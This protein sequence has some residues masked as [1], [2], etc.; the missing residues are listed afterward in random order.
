MVAVGTTMKL[1]A[2]ASELGRLKPLANV[3][4][5]AGSRRGR[6]T[7]RSIAEVS[8]MISHCRYNVKNLPTDQSDNW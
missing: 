3:R 4:Y 5:D 8:N 1:I 6:N 2:R 7:A